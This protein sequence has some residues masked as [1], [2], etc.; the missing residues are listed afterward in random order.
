MTVIPAID[1]KDGRCVRLHK[2]DFGTV[3]QVADDPLAVA[4]AY[5]DA[6]ASLIHVVDLDGALEGH[7]RNAGLVAAIVREAAPARVELG[8]GLRRMQ[9]MEEA[10]RLGVWRF[11]IGSAAVEDPDF[12]RQAVLRYGAR[13]AVG[14]DA[15]NG[16]VRTKGWTSGSDLEALTFAA[17]MESLGVDTLIFTDI[18]TDGMLTGPNFE[19]LRAL[20]ETVA[21]GVVA[22]GGVRSLADISAL[23]AAGLTGVIIGKALYEGLIDLT[24]C[25]QIVEK[26]SNL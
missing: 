24:K 20:R 7:R 6:G 15:K 10:D 16:I 21:C 14:I 2:G 3:H 17:D 8:G 1:L 22:S 23:K 12:V 25:I 18:D 5:R 11:V 26:E 19:Q 13:V 9:D 4:R